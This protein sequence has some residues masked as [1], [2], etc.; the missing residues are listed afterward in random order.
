MLA[1][2]LGACLDDPAVKD[3]L[4]LASPPPLAWPSPAASGAPPE[5]APSASAGRTGR[6]LDV[7]L[8]GPGYFLLAT[9]E[10]PTRWSEIVLSREGRFVWRFYPEAPAGAS[11]DANP[12]PTYGPGK[13]R[14]ESED[15]LVALGFSLPGAEGSW[16]PE[17]IGTSVDAALG[18][19]VSGEIRALGL[20]F[21]GNRTTPR[22][23][24]DFQGRLIDDAGPWLDDQGAEHRLHLAV[25]Q[26]A[27]P[28]ALGAVGARGRYRY[29]PAAG[30][31]RV[32]IPA[33]RAGASEPARALGDS[34][35]LRPGWLEAPGP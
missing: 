2:A 7:A 25:A 15:G 4:A 5:P 9:A 24:L 13:F 3:R 14:L 6:G 33:A 10:R 20:D 21:P 30:P 17:Q 23:R 27:R 16:P 18:S 35:A 22:P 19:P 31:L 32:G 1:L 8:E 29:D 12:A 26:V 34:V 28:D 11:P